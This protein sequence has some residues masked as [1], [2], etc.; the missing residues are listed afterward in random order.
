MVLV[1]ALSFKQ[2][3]RRPRGALFLGT[4]EADCFAGFR[5]PL[6]NFL[7]ID[8]FK[9]KEKGPYGPFL[10][11]SPMRFLTIDSTMGTVA[12]PVQCTVASLAD[13]AQLSNAPILTGRAELLKEHSTQPARRLNDGS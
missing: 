3:K 13:F 11:N 5:L 6:H 10:Y 8:G 2:R 1:T 9:A 12:F 4:L 7:T